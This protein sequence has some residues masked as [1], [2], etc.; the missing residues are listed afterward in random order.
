[1]IVRER[2]FL[3]DVLNKPSIPRRSM[4]RTMAADTPDW[5]I[6]GG[7]RVCGGLLLLLSLLC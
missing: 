6:A 7:G 1:M 2:V 5:K 4:R 3:I